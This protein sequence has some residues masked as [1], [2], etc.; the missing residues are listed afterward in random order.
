M[1]KFFIGS[2]LSVLL[3]L[4]A[5]K[6]PAEP[7]S[8]AGDVTLTGCLTRTDA[9]FVINGTRSEEKVV[10]PGTARL[11]AY[12][13]QVVRLTG[14]VRLKHGAKVFSPEKVSVLSSSCEAAPSD[15]LPRVVPHA[16][17]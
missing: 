8:G 5:Q 4:G 1:K 11:E 17:A 2:T 9:E 10:I 15:S 7:R 6:P 13:H 16:V 3:A 14:K 12:V